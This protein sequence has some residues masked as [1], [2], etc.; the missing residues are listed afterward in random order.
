MIRYRDFVPRMLR[1]AGL[2]QPAEHEEMEVANNEADQFIKETGKRLIKIETV[3][4]PTIWSRFEEGPSDPALGTSG[5][6]PSHWHQ[7]I[8]VWYRD[9]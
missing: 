9:D 7:F 8:R 2:F 4:L 5:E 3:V 6:S 1:P